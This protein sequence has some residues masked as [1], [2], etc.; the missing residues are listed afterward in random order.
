MVSGA[1]VSNLLELFDIITNNQ[2]ILEKWN[3]A[4]KDFIAQPRQAITLDVRL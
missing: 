2:E 3:F 4:V 1:R